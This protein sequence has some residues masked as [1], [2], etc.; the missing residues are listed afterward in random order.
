M[1]LQ[2]PANMLDLPESAYGQL[3]QTL[4]AK[5]SPLTTASMANVVSAL[6]GD[7]NQP[8]EAV[9]TSDVPSKSEIGGEWP[10]AA[11][12]LIDSLLRENNRLKAELE[13]LRSQ[14]QQATAL[15]DHDVLT[16]CLNRRAFVRD[17][18]RAMADCRRYSETACLI[19]LDMDGF[20]AINDTYGHMAG[21]KALIHVAD[22][23]KANIR[24]GDSVGRMGGDEF[25]VLLRRAD[26]GVAKSKAQKLEAELQLG[27]FEH[28]GLYL[29]TSG[30]FGVRAYEGQAT[31]EAWIAEADA[32]MFL[33]KKS[34][35]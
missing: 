21:D 20:K 16:P 2:P 4:E 24:E 35:R 1:S 10:F 6:F 28:E 8:L 22:M 29:K 25:A 12:A 18:V 15:A 31:A 14:V 33:V 19:F 5:K 27:T 13:T 7:K 30:S 23:L 34:G 3:G 17:M 32:A 11:R 26:I 9:V